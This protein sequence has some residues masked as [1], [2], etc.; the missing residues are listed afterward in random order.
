[1]EIEMDTNEIV[2]DKDYYCWNGSRMI[3]FQ[4]DHTD[5][6]SP[7]YG[8]LGNIETRRCGRDSSYVITY[9]KYDRIISKHFCEEHANKFIKQAEKANYKITDMRN[10]K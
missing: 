5:M 6:V 2:I 9:Q 7:P 1:M 10:V 3:Y 8:T 4:C